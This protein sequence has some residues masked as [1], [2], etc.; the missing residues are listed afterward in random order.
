MLNDWI[1]E[2][3]FNTKVSKFP[4]SSQRVC[5]VL[6]TSY[7]LWAIIAFFVSFVTSSYSLWFILLK[8]FDFAQN[9][10]NENIFHTKLSKFTRRSQRGC[11]FLATSCPLI[12]HFVCFAIYSFKFFW[13]H[14]EWNCSHYLT[15]LHLFPYH[16]A[17]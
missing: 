3:I 2:N 6:A 17:L 12:F 15:T 11:A 13:L 9:D 4:Q 16:K 8:F 14:S 5:A 1:V 7:P 10:E